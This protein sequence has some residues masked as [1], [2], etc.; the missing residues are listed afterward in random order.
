VLTALEDLSIAFTLAKFTSLLLGH[1]RELDYLVI[2]YFLKLDPP[3]GQDCVLCSFVIT[4]LEDSGSTV[5]SF[6]LF[7]QSLSFKKGLHVD[8]A[9]VALVHVNLDHDHQL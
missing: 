3:M 1:L 6:S 4:E 5:N 7:H 8:Q 2:V 9:H